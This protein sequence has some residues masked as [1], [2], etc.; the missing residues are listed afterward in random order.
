M[1]SRSHPTV[2]QLPLSTDDGVSVNMQG[3]MNSPISFQIGPYSN[4]LLG[5]RK[6]SGGHINLT[7]FFNI[8]A[9]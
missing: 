7:N 6:G 3:S 5:Q 2:N 4:N 8:F 9:S 1:A